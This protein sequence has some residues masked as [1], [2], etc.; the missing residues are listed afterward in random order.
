MKIAL[1]GTGQMGKAI[2]YLLKNKVKEDIYLTTFDRDDFTGSDQHYILH[3]RDLKNWRPTLST[4]FDC[5]FSALPYFLNEN[6]AKLARYIKTPYFDLGGSVP[7]SEKI[8]RLAQGY[9][10]MAF[11]DLGLAPGWV[12]IMAEKV[13][14]IFYEQNEVPY[15][16]KMRCGGLPENISSTRQDPFRYNCTW[17]IDGLYNEY[18]DDS[19]VL[20][21]GKIKTIKS[22]LYKEQVTPRY[23]WGLLGKKPE[24]ESFYT[25]GGASH[26][27][28]LMQKRGVQHCY[29]QTLRFPGHADLVYYFIHEKGYS[30]EEFAALFAKN[31]GD[32][33]VLLDV[34]GEN[35]DHYVR[36]SHIIH[37]KENWSAM[38][39]AT[40][41]GFIAAAL[42]TKL[43]PGPRDYSHVD[44]KKFKEIIQQCDILT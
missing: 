42:S 1:F 17:S 6:V 7:V 36:K 37:A 9:S 2:A 24:L 22:L 29:Y 41:G 10:H 11:T 3:P 20:S 31:N 33:V 30:K 4:N 38:Q 8:R 27:L 14:N 44:I 40:A 32:D 18:K 15:S 5:I 21:D 34:V 39:L 28:R 12:N 26:T 13:Y 19:E 43:G 35:Q 25:S 23:G 16:I